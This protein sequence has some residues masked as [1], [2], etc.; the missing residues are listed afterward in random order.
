MF[1]QVEYGVKSKPPK[2]KTSSDGRA[3]SDIR[4]GFRCDEGNSSPPTSCIMVF[5]SPLPRS[6][7]L[8]L[9][10]LSSVPGVSDGFSS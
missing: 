4:K 7:C 9:S 8:G 10:D 3:V 1:G 2:T 6:S 5:F